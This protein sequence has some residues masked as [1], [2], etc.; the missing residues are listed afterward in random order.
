MRIVSRENVEVGGGCWAVIDVD[1][2]QTGATFVKW[3]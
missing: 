3:L 1:I 2:F